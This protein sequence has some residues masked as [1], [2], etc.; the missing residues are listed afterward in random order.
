MISHDKDYS[1]SL[2]M[3][4]LPLWANVRTVPRIA[5]GHFFPNPLQFIIHQFSI[6]TVCSVDADGNEK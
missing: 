5:H 3:V 1:G 6:S 4:F 2:F